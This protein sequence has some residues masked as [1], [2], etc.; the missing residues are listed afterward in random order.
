VAEANE[1]QDT[2]SLTTKF[3]ALA[4]GGKNAIGILIFIGLIALSGLTIYEHI[5]RSTEHD[6]I[7]CMIKLNL[8]MQTQEP[9][10]PINWRA[11]PVDTFGCVPRFL[12]ERD[13]VK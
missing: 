1:G 4:L 11:L 5:Q 6:S 13:A 12:Y 9:N 7:N 3:G 8:Y 2:V 10:K